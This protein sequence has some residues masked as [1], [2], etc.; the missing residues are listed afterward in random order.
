MFI[1]ILITLLIQLSFIL[2][3]DLIIVSN[4]IKIKQEK[5]ELALKDYIE[6]K[7]SLG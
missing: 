1:G 2:N 4:V 6:D 3:K 7:I 5:L